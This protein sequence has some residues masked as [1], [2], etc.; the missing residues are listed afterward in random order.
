[1]KELQTL[2]KL[3]SVYSP[4][5]NEEE[6]RETL[7][8]VIE[9]V[10]G[11]TVEVWEDGAGNVLASPSKK[12]QYEVAL[13]SH[14][15][16]VPGF[17]QPKIVGDKVYGRG[18]VDAKGPLNAMI[19]ALAK[20]G[21]GPILLGAMVREETDS[22][23]AKYLKENG[24][25]ARYVIIGEPSNNTNVII[26]YRGYAWLKVECKAKG[27]HASSPEVG[28]SAVDKLIE[29][30]LKAKENLQP[31]TVSLTTIVSKNAFNVLP[32]EVVA[33]FDVRYPKGVELESILKAFEPCDV[34]LVD[35][36]PPAEV[37][38]SS[39]VPRAL[40]RAILKSGK[41]A[42]Y[43]KK[44]GTSDMN[45]LAEVSESIAAYGPGKS[46]LSHTDGEVMSLEEIKHA[47][48]V[49]E[50]AVRELLS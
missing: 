2:F 32:K 35:G 12:P 44:R 30:Y 15:D 26:G 22:Y 3:V 50:R 41:R 5:G 4:S 6:V 36:L 27:G 28:E 10:T 24:P 49:Y 37:K 34:E 43:A 46:E 20:I 42:R 23:G 19:W 16:T 17:P 39:P 21:E 25:K 48:E 29:L 9:E 14:M 8:E 13:I 31:A 7:K 40:A 38:P 33:Q 47:I 1:M 18:A 45:V 11:G